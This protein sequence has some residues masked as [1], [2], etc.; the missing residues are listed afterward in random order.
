MPDQDGVEDLGGTLRLGSYPCV[1]DRRLQS[2]MNCLARKKFRSVTDIVTKSTMHTVKNLT[3][4]RY[5][6]LPVLSPDGH[7]VEMI[8]IT[9]S[10]VLT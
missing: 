1:L 6:V 2:T 7:I 4:K 3:D 5:D 9:G 10:S 8:E